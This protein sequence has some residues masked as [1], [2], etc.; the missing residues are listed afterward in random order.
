V[1]W[2]THYRA[3]VGESDL[4]VV[5]PEAVVFDGIGSPIKKMP[6]FYTTT[7]PKCGKAAQRETDTFETTASGRTTGRSLSPTATEPQLGQLMTGIGQPQ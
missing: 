1:C 6:E 5:L 7:C 4:P 3:G 2:H